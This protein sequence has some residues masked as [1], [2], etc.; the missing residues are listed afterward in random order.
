MSR[1]NQYKRG[2]PYLEGEGV[3]RS[4]HLPVEVLT[5]LPQYQGTEGD[6]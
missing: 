4:L 1:S 3:G 2:S 5:E 6:L